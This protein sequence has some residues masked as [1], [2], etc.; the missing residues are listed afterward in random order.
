MKKLIFIAS[1]LAFSSCK[2][3]GGA[4][5]TAVGVV[6]DCTK[7]SVKNTARS[8]VPSVEVAM[9]SG[10]PEAALL[11]L[12]S[13]FGIDA[14]SCVVNHIV[15]RAQFDAKDAPN[16]ENTKAKIFNGSEFLKKQKVTFA[17]Q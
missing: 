2:T 5:K 10:N 9:V 3:M 6:V 1:L 16:D 7:E 15:M 13:N 11:S 14:V 4:G 8:I 17:K 12:V